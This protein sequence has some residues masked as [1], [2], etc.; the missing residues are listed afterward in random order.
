MI[1]SESRDWRNAF[2]A[3]VGLEQGDIPGPNKLE[4]HLE[5][6]SYLGDLLGTAKA[7]WYIPLPLRVFIQPLIRHGVHRREW[8]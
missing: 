8:S 7:D 6:K 1:Y 2:S 4:K 5:D 3:R